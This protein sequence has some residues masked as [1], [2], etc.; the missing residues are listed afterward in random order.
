M[1]R[2]PSDTWTVSRLLTWTAD[3]LKK[4]G[5]DSPRL[6]AEVL[7][8]H[9]LE[10]PRV[11]LYTHFEDEVGE[12]AKATYRDLV[13]RRSEGAPVAYLVGKKEFFSMDF[14]VS[15]VVL[16]PRPDTET[17][18][19]AALD[20]LKGR[21]SPHVVDV[22]TGSG[23]IALAIAKG[24]PTARVIAIDVSP[25]ALGVATSNAASLNLADRVD[26][27]QGDLLEPVVGEGPFD[28]IVSN[29]PYIPTSDIDELEQGVRDYEPHL[30]LDG[31]PDG[32]RIVQR[33]VA[34]AAESLVPGGSL[35]IEIGSAQEEAVRSLISEV[36]GLVLAPTIRDAANHPRVIL[37]RRSR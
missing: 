9:V 37:A 5:S 35:V 4:K 20:C 18:V 31:G 32:L 34:S 14:A 25:E 28:L 2:A 11:K 21:P 36:E 27:R 16:I 17:A 33:L 8:S 22:G 29:P 23:C 30:A 3:F 12:R 24:C 13:K 15:S 1:D 6:D 7:L 10:W 19:V 26:F